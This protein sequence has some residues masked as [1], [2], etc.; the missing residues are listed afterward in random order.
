[1]MRKIK[2]REEIRKK[3]NEREDKEEAIRNRSRKKRA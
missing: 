2:E 1:M 3:Q